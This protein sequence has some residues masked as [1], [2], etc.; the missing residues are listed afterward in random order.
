MEVLVDYA[1]LVNKG[2]T[3]EPFL[4][5]VEPN[6]DTMS[7]D[8]EWTGKA[9]AMKNTIERSIKLVTT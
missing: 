3:K 2:D 8:N 4:V 5:I 1:Y 9:T 7:V 6:E